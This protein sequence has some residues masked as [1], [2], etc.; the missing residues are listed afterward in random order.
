MR[1]RRRWRRRSGRPRPRSP[2]RARTGV[3]GAGRPDL[4]A[5]LDPAVAAV[6][7]LE[8]E[9]VGADQRVDAGA[10][11]AGQAAG[12]A[13]RR[14]DE[15]PAAAIETATATSDLRRRRAVAERG[16]D[17]AGDRADGEHHEDQVERSPSRATG[18]DQRHD[19]PPEP[20]HTLI[21]GRVL[22]RVR[23]VRVT[24]RS[25]GVAGRPARR[26]VSGSPKVSRQRRRGEA[27]ARSGPPRRPGRRAAAARA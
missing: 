17:A 1:R 8:H 14:P 9:P 4:A 10:R 18:E 23:A 6:D 13:A 26:A 15:R 22:T 2:A 25:G 5:D 3:V 16:H 20:G 11:V 19:E 12:G 24:G 7:A 21:L 27:P